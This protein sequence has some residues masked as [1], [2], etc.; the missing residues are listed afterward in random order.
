MARIV[1]ISCSVVSRHGVR[2]QAAIQYN[3]TVTAI[4]N[5]PKGIATVETNNKGGYRVKFGEIEKRFGRNEPS[6]VVARNKAND[7]A[8]H[9]SGVEPYTRKKLFACGEFSLS[10]HKT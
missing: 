2:G 7:L 9:W 4:W 1:D 6:S 5:G 3:W 10:S 8:K